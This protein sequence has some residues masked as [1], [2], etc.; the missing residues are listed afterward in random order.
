[1]SPSTAASPSSGSASIVSQLTRH[2]RLVNFARGCRPSKRYAAS[3]GSG[4]SRTTSVSGW[5]SARNR[6]H[7][8]A[9]NSSPK[10]GWPAVDTRWM[11]GFFS[12]SLPCDTSFNLAGGRGPPALA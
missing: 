11:V 3:P 4:Q 12:F 5:R 2:S 1:M 9:M 7:D 6:S 10:F 8:A